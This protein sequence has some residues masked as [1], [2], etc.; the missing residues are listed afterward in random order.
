VSQ[1]AGAPY[2]GVGFEVLTAVVMKIVSPYIGVV[3]GGA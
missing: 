2:I 1:G 3:I